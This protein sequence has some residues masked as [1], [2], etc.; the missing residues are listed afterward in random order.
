[1][2]RVNPDLIGDLDLTCWTIAFCG[3]EPVRATTLR[4]FAEVFG[5]CGFRASAFRPCYGL[6]EATLMV[7]GRQ[8][9]SATVVREHDG[10]PVLSCGRAIRGQRIVIVDPEDRLG[11]P[12]GQIGEIWVSGPS[13]APGY[14]Q[15]P[16]ETLAVFDSV[17]ADTGEGGFLRT[18][19]LGFL[20]GEELFVTG[21]MKELIIIGGRNFHPHDIED[22]IASAVPALANGGGAAFSV[23]GDGD[24]DERLVV[25]QEPNRSWQDSALDEVRSAARKTVSEQFGISLHDLVLIRPTTL[26]RTS[27]GK[28]RRFQA[29]SLYLSRGLALLERKPERAS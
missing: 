18:G 14:W 28:P 13:V 3:A 9:G 17:R 26:P 19:D 11:L 5:R 25:I 4:R 6:A 24:G 29:R 20:Q 12:D 15:Q 7:S 1:V 22:A 23:N 21:R 8:E 16:Q 27:S 10:R 2:E